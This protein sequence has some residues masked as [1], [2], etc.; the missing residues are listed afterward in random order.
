MPD[1]NTKLLIPFEGNSNDICGNEITSVG[2]VSVSNSVSKF[3]NGSGY[4]NG[5][6]LSATNNFGE[7]SVTSTGFAVDSWF[8]LDSVAPTTSQQLFCLYESASRYW[9]FQY[10]STNDIGTGFKLA[11]LYDSNGSYFQW[12]T[13][14]VQANTW[15]H[16]GYQHNNTNWYGGDLYLNGTQITNIYYTNT[17]GHFYRPT[18]TCEL[19]IGGGFNGYCDEFRFSSTERYSEN[20]TPPTESYIPKPVNY[21][22]CV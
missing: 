4:F 22:F 5:G 7:W 9:S 6:Y 13:N 18:G 17:S 12:F 1:N 16:I 11:W 2:S 14:N 10:F 20:F 3:G 8:K 19:R 15:F 21:A